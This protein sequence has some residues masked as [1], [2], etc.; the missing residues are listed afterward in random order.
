MTTAA[1][2]TRPGR[3][4][5]VILAIVYAIL[6]VLVVLLKFP[7]NGPGST[8]RVLNLIPY[9]YALTTGVG[10]EQVIENV[11]A[12][13]PYGIYLSMLWP[14][15]GFW[16][17]FLPILATTVVFET[18]QY[19]LAIGR[20]DITDV[21]D[22][23]LGGVLGIAIYAV[24]ARILKGRTNLVLNILLAVV[25]VAFLLFCLRL[26]THDLGIPLI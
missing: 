15:L 23:A 5:T 1:L 14:R 11:L 26:F 6:L 3:P 9:H 17:K 2:A 24:V 19:V 22:N 8:V 21:I 25:T 12:F 16:A 20:A 10:V 13:V 4:L 18:I 7:F